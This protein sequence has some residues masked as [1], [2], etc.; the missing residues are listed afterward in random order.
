MLLLSA[1]A[2]VPPCLF[3][4]A[5]AAVMAAC[6]AGTSVAAVAAAVGL[7]LAAVVSAAGFLLALQGFLAVMASICPPQPPPLV[8]S[9]VAAAR[10]LALAPATAVS[11]GLSV[12]QVVVAI[13]AATAAAAFA[14]LSQ[15]PVLVVGLSFSTILSFSLPFALL[16]FF[17]K[18]FLFFFFLFGG[19]GGREGGVS[20]FSRSF[21]C[22]FLGRLVVVVV[23]FVPGGLCFVGGWSP[24][25]VVC[26]RSLFN[27]WTLRHARSRPSS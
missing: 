17:L 21:L 10:A 20:C 5:V 9:V 22:F 27:G 2:S 8:P 11:A 13:A 12:A 4:A 7:F 23:L 16:P 1:S 3:L 26:A 15:S 18:L 24:P 19:T 14:L 25:L 6:A